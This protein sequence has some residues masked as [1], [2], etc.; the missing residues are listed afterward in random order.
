MLNIDVEGCLVLC[1]VLIYVE[2][3]DLELVIDVV[4]LIGVVIIV[5]GYYVIVVMS[6]YNLFVY[7]LFNV[8]E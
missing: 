2:C 8:L 1:D 4:M 5:F 7:E 3:F 6:M